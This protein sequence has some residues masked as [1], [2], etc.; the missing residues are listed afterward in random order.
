MRAQA[1]EARRLD[2]EARQSVLHDLVVGRH[3]AE[4][5]PKVGELLH[6]EAAVLREHHG[7]HAVEARFQIRERCDL[8]L[9]RHPFA[10]SPYTAFLNMFAIA[11]ASIGTPG[12]IVVEMVSERR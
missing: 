9:G 2:R 3:G 7:L 1:L 12:P 8:F 6:A 10:P 11:C 5:L 4:L